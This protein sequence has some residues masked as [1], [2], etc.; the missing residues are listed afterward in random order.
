MSGE[1]RAPAFGRD[2]FPE[3]TKH[4]TFADWVEEGHGWAA[5][6][7]YRKGELKGAVADFDVPLPPDAPAVP[8]DY[9]PAARALAR[10]RVALAAHR[11]A[12]KLRANLPA[13]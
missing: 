2:R 5:E 3:L 7:V 9:E 10:Q 6:V 11:L 13:S 1:L 8:D 12:D 4:P